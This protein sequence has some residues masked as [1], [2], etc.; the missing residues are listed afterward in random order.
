MIFLF[1]FSHRRWK[2]TTC[3]KILSS[4]LQLK[5][6]NKIH[7]EVWNVS[8]TEPDSSQKDLISSNSG[9]SG[10][11]TLDV[12]VNPN[13]SVSEKVLMDAVA[14]RK[15]MDRTDVSTYEYLH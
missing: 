11:T 5:F 15:S 9:L 10:I 3:Q 2:C 6:H 1:M 13:P 12:Q 4:K 7:T 14:E 8:S